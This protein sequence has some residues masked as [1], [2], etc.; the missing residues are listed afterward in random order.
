MKLNN[1]KIIL[2]IELLNLCSKLIFLVV[3]LYKE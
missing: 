1:V 2:K 3:K